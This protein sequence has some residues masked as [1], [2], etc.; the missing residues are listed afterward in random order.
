MLL[1]ASK[2]ATP[3]M[4]INRSSKNACGYLA[5]RINCVAIASSERALVCGN[6]L[7]ALEQTA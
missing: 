6:R 1:L 2:Q 7:L 4:P 3:R 5:I